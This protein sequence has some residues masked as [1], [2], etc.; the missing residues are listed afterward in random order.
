MTRINN[1]TALIALAIMLASTGC[2]DASSFDE[3]AGDDALSASDTTPALDDELELACEAFC[4]ASAPCRRALAG[5]DCAARCV[6]E[7][8]REAGD[9]CVAAQ[10]DLLNCF[11]A[12][13]CDSTADVRDECGDAILTL[14]SVCGPS[15][16]RREL[17]EDGDGLIEVVGVGGGEWAD[18]DVDPE[19]TEPS[20]G[21]DD[22][23][24]DESE[25]SDP[26]FELPEI[27]EY[28]EIPEIGPVIEFP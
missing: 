25:D 14:R 27:P 3:T 23:E 1:I 18:V 7:Y 15:G 21:S 24:P 16:L 28:P 6:N 8:E 2:G 26:I 20:E 13:T 9:A 11:S 17:D 19:E 10:I 5:E 12:T 4:D 22:E